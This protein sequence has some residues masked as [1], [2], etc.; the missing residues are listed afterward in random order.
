MAEQLLETEVLLRRIA[1][2]E[3]QV[4]SLQTEVARLGGENACLQA[5]NARLQAENAEL[6]RRLGLNSGNSHKPPSS[7]GYRKKRVQ[8]AL[9]KGEKQAA[10]GRG[11][12]AGR[13]AR[14]RSPIGCVCNVGGRLP[15][16]SR[17]RW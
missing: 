14:W 5:E 6:Q 12:K 2:L 9:P 15:R 17:T 11:T 13:C 3:A 7:D 16:T 4:A 10:A 1:S 8:P